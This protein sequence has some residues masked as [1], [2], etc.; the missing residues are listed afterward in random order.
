MA[1]P[2]TIGTRTFDTQAAA[3]EFIR[4]V[5]YKHPLLAPIDCADHAFLLELLSKH[6]Q[7]AEK[8]GVGVKYFTVEN[9]KGGT[10]CFYITRIDG[11]QS[12]FSFMKC[13]RGRD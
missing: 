8:I 3:V 2:L 12:D 6:P 5:L 7:A 1:K 13:L 9:A 11:S 10:Q 4:E